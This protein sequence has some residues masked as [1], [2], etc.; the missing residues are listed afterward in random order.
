[1]LLELVYELVIG[2][3]RLELASVVIGYAT[4]IL[5][6]KKLSIRKIGIILIGVIAIVVFINSG[7]F[8]RFNEALQMQFS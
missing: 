8:E 3:S 5:L 4:M 7:Y 2:Q 1:M 6:M